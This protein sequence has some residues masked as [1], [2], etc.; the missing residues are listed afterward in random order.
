MTASSRSDADQPAPAVAAR[1]FAR[2][3]S[4]ESLMQH[5]ARLEATLFAG[6][7]LEQLFTVEAALDA[8]W[9]SETEA[10]PQREL[11]W[12]TEDGE[13]A[14]DV[15]RLSAFDSDGRVLLRR[16]YFAGADGL[17][18]DDHELVKGLRRG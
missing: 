14:I 11:V 12:A 15:L 6:G 18:R 13:A 4:N 2:V 8:A 17:V 1:R 7:S 5:T 10:R 9:S 3:L 16:T